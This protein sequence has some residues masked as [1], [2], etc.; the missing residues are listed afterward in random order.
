[1]NLKYFCFLFIV[2]F[3]SMSHADP[4]VVPR[5]TVYDLPYTTEANQYNSEQLKRN[6]GTLVGIGVATMGLL[7]LM[8]SSFTN[9]D[10][11]DTKYPT[12]KWWKN[13]S[14]H[15]VWDKD[16]VF[17]NYVTH[18]YAGAIYYMGARSAGVS[19]MG[20]F[21][22]S[23]VLSTFF[24]EY[25][26]EA[27]AERPSIQDLIVTPIAGSLIGE[28]F[29]TS[30]RSILENNGELWGSPVLGKTAIFLMDPITEISDLIWGS[31]ATKKSPFSFSSQPIITHGM[32]WGYGF[33][34]RIEF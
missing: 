19:A 31:E 20:S 2:L 10:D 29:Y 13:V 6:S 15:P 30:K 9:W 16:D 24:W 1:M 33:N 12:K 8:P 5:L 25:G 4:D 21:L 22:Y 17:L 27:F 28:L 32:H 14:H 3:A 34:L 23:T 7:Y 11:E 26:I 18:P